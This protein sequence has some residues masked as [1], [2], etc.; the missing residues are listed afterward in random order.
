VL[1]VLCGPFA[2]SLYLG[3]DPEADDGVRR[4]FDA[5]GEMAA[6][7][8]GKIFWILGIDMAHMGARYQDPFQAQAGEGIMEAVE[9]RDRDRIARAAAGDA[10]AFW[11]AV[12]PN[13]DDLKWC[14]ASPVYT[15]LKSVP[16]LRGELLHYQQWNIDPAS[17]VSFAGMAFSERSTPAPK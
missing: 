16:N 10:A 9:Q 1:P 6:L 7:E 5:L 17:V 11:E 8:K 13:H 12:R 15:F 3:G 14:G 4:F 2:R